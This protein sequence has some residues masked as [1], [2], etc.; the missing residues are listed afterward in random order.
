MLVGE[1]VLYLNSE[2]WIPLKMPEGITGEVMF[3]DNGDGTASLLGVARIK[4]IALDT[5]YTLLLA[6]KGY[7]FVSDSFHYVNDHYI[8]GL[9]GY[10]DS[11]GMVTQSNFGRA[12]AQVS[13][14]SGN[15]IVTFTGTFPNYH[16]NGTSF[17]DFVFMQN[18]T[19]TT[20]TT[21]QIAMT[22][23]VKKV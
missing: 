9:N 21:E 17:I 10:L 13:Y 15:M 18:T 23:N 3:R 16:D 2:G 19:L 22:I 6:P 7:E 12:P 11:D 5:P 8:S 14:D 4:H 1:D 20:G